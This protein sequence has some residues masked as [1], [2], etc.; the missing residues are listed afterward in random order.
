MHQ[1]RPLVDGNQA[2]LCVKILKKITFKVCSLWK[3][4]VPMDGSHLNSSLSS[5][6]GSSVRDSL[7]GS[8]RSSVRCS[9]NSSLN[10]S[11]SL[12]VGAPPAG[13]FLWGAQMTMLDAVSLD[14]QHASS[15]FR[16]TSFAS[17]QEQLPKRFWF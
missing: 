16:T 4:I 6:V 1:G 12:S 7:S 8:V 2:S 14:V 11:L 9:L 10:G 3:T 17:L 15:A 13:V 5:S